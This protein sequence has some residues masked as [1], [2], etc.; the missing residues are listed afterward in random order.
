M[1]A[2]MLMRKGNISQGP[3]S[4]ANYR[5]LTTLG[6]RSCEPPRWLS[7]EDQSV[8]KPYRYHPQ[9]WIQTGCI[10][11]RVY[12]TCTH[13]YV[14]RYARTII[15]EA[16]N[17]SVRGM[18]EGLKKWEELERRKGRGGDEIL[19]QLNTFFFLF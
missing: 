2:G 17:L 11:I 10:Y 8:L 13:M 16:V 15:K 3:R 9:K 12:F 19:F 18:W 14:C 1:S 7:S 6:R 5:K 4:Q